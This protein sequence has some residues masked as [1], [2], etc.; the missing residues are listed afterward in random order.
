LFCA[1]LRLIVRDTGHA[2]QRGEIGDVS[3]NSDEAVA[4][5][6]IC[7]AAVRS[8]NA[9]PRERE[10]TIRVEVVAA[11]NLSDDFLVGHRGDR[12]RPID[13]EA[14]QGLISALGTNEYSSCTS[15]SSM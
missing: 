14:L 4:G 6:K 7:A 12:R 2:F 15:P 3:R 13:E 5:N 1:V 11:A 10:R 9:A 8:E